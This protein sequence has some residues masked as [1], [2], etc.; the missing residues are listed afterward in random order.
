MR[1]YS[2]NEILNASKENNMTIIN[3]EE[4][5]TRNNASHK[6]WAVCFTLQKYK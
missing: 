3:C 5:Y 2:M 1:H 6:T 4:I